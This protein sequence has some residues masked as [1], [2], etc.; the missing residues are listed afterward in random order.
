MREALHFLPEGV[1]DVVGRVPSV[2]IHVKD[3]LPAPVG[4]IL[5]IN[6]A[7]IINTNIKRIYLNSYLN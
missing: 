1:A 7:N 4:Y 3:I 6:I 2:Y 5:N